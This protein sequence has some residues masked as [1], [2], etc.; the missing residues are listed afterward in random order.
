[1]NLGTLFYIERVK[2][3]NAASFWVS[4]AVFA[5]FVG[6]I[7]MFNFYGTIIVNGQEVSAMQ[8]PRD[9][10]RL[11]SQFKSLEVIFVPLA[12]ILLTASE[13]ASKTA[14]QNVID[15]LSREE[16][17]AGKALLVVVIVLVY[18][19]LS[20]LIG[21]LF[22]LGAKS[23]GG[24][25]GALMGLNELLIFSAHFVALLGYGFLGLFFAFLTR[26]AGSAIALYVLY[27]VL[28]GLAG[29]LLQFSETF[30][31]VVKFLPTKA[32]DDLVNSLRFDADAL[33][34]LRAQLKEA[35]E[36]WQ[37]VPYGLD[38]QLPQFETPA[39][40]SLA[41]F[42]VALAIS[43]TYLLFKRRDL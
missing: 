19:L 28:E 16:F 12:L 6:L 1:M 7:S 8:L 4:L 35:E 20:L 34:R 13:F 24:G 31:P 41:F 23:D 43:A 29:G 14:R 22:N 32:F 33:A 27:L 9:W 25:H 38:A 39:A 26:A 17:V 40:F 36:A 3:M 15:G 11:L 21:A 30:K 37:S 10:A 42:Y 5:A 2:T 18:F